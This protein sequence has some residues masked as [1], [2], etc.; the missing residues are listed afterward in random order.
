M[1]CGTS[2]TTWILFSKRYNLPQGKRQSS[3]P[4]NHITLPMTLVSFSLTTKTTNGFVL[5]EKT[6]RCEVIP[7]HTLARMPWQTANRLHLAMLIS[8][9]VFFYGIHSV[10]VKLSKHCSEMTCI[11][12]CVAKFLGWR[13]FSAVTIQYMCHKKLFFFFT[14]KL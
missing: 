2:W 6:L 8:K 5:M 4:E 14:M 12:N 7:L 13:N 10:I 1:G 3:G 9:T 11:L